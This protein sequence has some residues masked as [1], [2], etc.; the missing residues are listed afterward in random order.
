MKTFSIILTIL[1]LYFFVYA[2]A[3][4]PCTDDGC[5]EFNELTIPEPLEDIRGEIKLYEKLVVPVIQTETKE[6]MEI[7]E[8]T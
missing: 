7:K 6:R 5:P 3:E 2:C 1:G 4:K 8:C